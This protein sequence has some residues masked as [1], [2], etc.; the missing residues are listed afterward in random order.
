[1]S[2]RQ[3]IQEIFESS[4]SS[5]IFVI[6]LGCTLALNSRA[7]EPNDQAA[8]FFNARIQPLLELHCYECHS[9]Q[10]KKVKG[11][12][13]LDSRQG[14][15]TGGESGA[16][17]VPESPEKSLLI[18]AV[19]YQEL[20]MPPDGRLS[21]GEL[22]L[23]EEWIATGAYD[24]RESKGA[25][26]GPKMDIEAGR[27]HWAFQPLRT[28]STFKLTN[29]H[30]PRTKVDQ[31]ILGK[32]ESKGISP[33]ADADSYNWLRRVF[34]DL[35]GLPPSLA[36]IEAF[37]LE[38]SPAARERVVDRLLS[39]DAFGERWARHWLDLV[40][41]A[42][43]VGTSNNVFA[44]HAWRYRDYVIDAYNHDKP[45]DQFVR[46]QIA[47]DLLEYENVDQ[48][49]AS[50]TGTGFLVLGDIEIVESDK[51]K[52]LVD[53]VDQQ[54]NKVGK[55]FLGL[56]LECARCHDHK[57]DP[58][59][60]RD[61]FAMAGFFHSTSTVFKT[62]RGVWSDVNVVELPETEKQRN[63]RTQRLI[64][65]R[66]KLDRW[67]NDRKKAKSEKAVIEA[68][69][70]ESGLT[71]DERSGIQKERDKQAGRI[72][73][74]KQDIL[75]AQ[76]FAPAP[77]RAHGV[78]DF[79]KPS[80]MR[81]TIRGN[82]RALGDSVPRGFLQVSGGGRLKISPAESGRRQLADW[83][84]A[85]PLSARV[86]VNRIWQKL[87]GEGLVRTVDYFGVP[88]DRPADPGLLDFLAQQLIDH[89]WSQKQLIRSLVL[90]RVYGLD[91]AHD[92][93]AAASDPGNRYHW[94]MNGFRLDAE[95]LRDAMLF[96][97]D[98]L[99]SSSGG[100]AMPLEFPENVGGLDPKDVNPPSFRLSKWRL[101][102]EFER[103]IYLPVIRHAAQP[104]PA[105]LR[106]VF[107]FAD[108][109]QFSG[110]R[111]VTAVPT[112]ALFLMNS[113]EV[114]EHA[115]ALVE[116]TMSVEDE[117]RRLEVLW[118]TL[119]N[120]PIAESE[121]E[122]TIRFISAAGKN[123]WVELCHALLAS[124]EFLMRL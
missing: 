104:K 27:K 80:D 106:N 19:R 107:D 40:G 24:P 35:T 65:H 53:I 52:L 74:L 55:A 29:S 58:I 13:V 91:S 45:F 111:A 11:G 118:L 15:E 114:K 64:T 94:R 5:W 98:R 56:T 20:E 86:V 47:G 32:L 112:Q 38:D 97:S 76:F 69:L 81:M 117:S 37:T 75:H 109:S 57:F 116:R 22:G 119:L 46:E 68:R 50:I 66:E 2:S 101:G 28:A 121:K 44:E 31:L 7:A 72:S 96:V 34:F 16:A 110:K 8:T 88:G 63:E 12:L 59:P 122:E 1:M 41:Y 10:S 78:R 77:P 21:A 70:K 3:S 6:L 17:I 82:P 89:G 18:K 73:K 49:A 123:G 79:E 23:L 42:D 30:W 61:Y 54:L 67:E 113:P 87:F 84:V 62:D 36:D 100:P 92:A 120:R 71:E 39:S 26:N 43:Q 33:V 60:Q 90:S 14:W 103:T 25:L 93:E 4:R 99:K 124:N 105:N 9:H 83:I 48:Q 51:E 102:Q 115:A 85:Q 95:A 108:P